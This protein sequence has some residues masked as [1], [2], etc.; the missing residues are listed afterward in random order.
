M[1]YFYNTI[2][3][4][5]RNL[6]KILDIL[7]NENSDAILHELKD[8]EEKIRFLKKD[9]EKY[10]LGNELR[11]EQAKDLY[12]KYD[13]NYHSS[14]FGYSPINSSNQSYI[15][16]ISFLIGIIGLIVGGIQI[17]NFITNPSSIQYI[18]EKP[19]QLIKKLNLRY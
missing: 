5:T 4:E 8:N 11:R 13:S 6:G 3:D 17:A 7:K 16:F 19:S 1:E 12:E 10:R 14:I 15:I 2:V 18:K 9:N